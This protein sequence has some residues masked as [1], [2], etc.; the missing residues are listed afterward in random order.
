MTTKSRVR[1][2]AETNRE[3]HISDEYLMALDTM[4]FRALLDRLPE[5][6]DELRTRRQRLQHEAWR[7]RNPEKLREWDRRYYHE[8][9]P[10][11]PE[12]RRERWRAAAQRSRAR[13]R[14]ARLEALLADANEAEAREL[15]AQIERLSQLA[16]TP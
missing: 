12:Q 2:A 16:Q 15:R 5:Q 14:I 10:E 9:S 8:R 1:P 6:A 13:R 4:A 11:T 3:E 7:E